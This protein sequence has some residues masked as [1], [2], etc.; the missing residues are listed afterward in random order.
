[1]TITRRNLLK[2][3]AAATLA[4][5]AASLPFLGRPAFAADI[6]I[7]HAS[8]GGG[9]GKTWRGAFAE[10]YAAAGAADVRIVEVPNPEAQFRA[11]AGAPQYNSGI[12]TF[13]QGIN[14]M[15]DG[16]VELFDIEE[17]P[18]MKAIDRKYW[19]T[20]DDGR[21]AG[22]TPYF[23]Y[24]GIA[25]NTQLAKA[26]DFKSWRNLADPKWK[27][28]LSMTRPIY[29]STYDLTIMAK[30]TGGDE[31]N[32]TSGMELLTG[33]TKNILNI[34]TSLAQQ[35]T[36]LARGEVVAMPFYSVRVWSLREAGNQD[37]EIVIP[38]EGALLLPYAIV[39]PKGVANREATAKWLNYIASAIPQERGMALSGYI[40]ASSEAKASPE[41]RAKLGMTFEEMRAKL[42]QPDWKYI[43]AHHKERVEEIDR[44]IAA[45]Q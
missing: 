35:N 30:A 34:G 38:D 9:V 39:A 16:L 20:T 33:M 28:R 8:W 36:M 18:A 29:L 21:I 7:I 13:V 5:A 12:C 17:L 40:P 4:P 22:V 3:T 45:T 25:L 37:V 41:I 43:A 10:P 26:S 27:G 44:M 42:Y 19:L 2:S 31:R 1:M 6:E 14:L 23:A 24:Y 15:N 32:Y 11:Q